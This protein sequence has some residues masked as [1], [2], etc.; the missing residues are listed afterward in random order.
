M[1]PRGLHIFERMRVWAVSSQP[2]KNVSRTAECKLAIST[3]VRE[4]QFHAMRL[5]M[6]Q[7]SHFRP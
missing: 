4:L 7:P 3:E 6:T 1:Q 2:R 5:S